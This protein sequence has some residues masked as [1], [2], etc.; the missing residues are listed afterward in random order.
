ME[1]SASASVVRCGAFN[2]KKS[3]TE[4]TNSEILLIVMNDT[5]K[6][7]R[8][9]RFDKFVNLTPH[10]VTVVSGG[11]VKKYLRDGTVARVT[12]TTTLAFSIDEV[13]INDVVFGD[14]IGLPAPVKG[15]WFI[16]SAMVKEAVKKSGSGRNDCVS[17]GNL[18]RN[19]KG[20]VIG[21]KGF[22]R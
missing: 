6:F 2:F 7:D 9:D 8:F 16:V 18:I 15:V 11:K 1:K 17:P 4:S 13:D 19:E 3:L 21:C 14:I 12:E 10:D 20:E 5:N 22:A